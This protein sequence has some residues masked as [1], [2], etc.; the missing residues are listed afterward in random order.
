MDDL[1]ALAVQQGGAADN[2]GPETFTYRELV[3]TIGRLIGVPPIVG[4]WAG[5]LVGALT[6]D[7]TITRAE[8]SGLMADLLYVETPPTGATKL[9]D[10]I[11]P[12]AD[13]LGRRYTSELVRRVDRVGR[14]G[15]I[16]EPLLRGAG[17]HRSP[18]PVAS[19]ALRSAGCRPL[20]RRR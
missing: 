2:I 10:W 12:H 9:T 13:S 14:I 19:A 16:D 5:R 15:A 3:E 17:P 4:Y 7:V 18:R 20:S 8:I 6:G 1:A 11:A